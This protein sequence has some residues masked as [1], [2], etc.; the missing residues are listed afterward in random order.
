MTEPAPHASAPADAAADRRDPH[1]FAGRR[2]ALATLHDKAEALAPAFGTL[3]MR[4]IVPAGI[5]TDALGTFSG[6]VPRRGTALDT[7]IAK[8]RL[9]M[10]ATG[11][12]LGLATEGS[13]GPDPAIG[14][15]PL[16]RE[17]AVLVDDLH[18][19]VVCEFLQTHE[20]N[21]AGATCSAGQPPD[22]ATLARWGFPAHALLVRSEPLGPGGRVRKGLRDRA[23]LDAAIA[24]CAAA[25]PDGRVRVETDM[26]AHCNPTRMRHIR[27]LGLRLVE[28]LRSRCPACAA[29]GFGRIDVVAGLPC[30][31]CGAPT[32]A[33][34]AEV[35]GCGACGERRE[36]PRGDGR[37]HADPGACD[38]C[39]P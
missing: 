5:D 36:I 9:G 23:A 13:F 32:R 33:L 18:G 3:G 29:P 25:A 2:V 4:V 1:P 26:R 15:V 11:L 6:E 38:R 7:A 27:A 16:H 8:A 28:R 31:A 12:P 10:A 39:N 24:A 14:F 37:A 17:L 20:T 34:L 22:D 30:A 19:Q 21:H 35:H